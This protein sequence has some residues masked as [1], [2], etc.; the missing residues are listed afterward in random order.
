MPSSAR[1]G[2][3]PLM[4]PPRAGVDVR[5]A[6]QPDAERRQERRCLLLGERARGLPAGA[7]A[8]AGQPHEPRAL[9]RRRH[10]ARAR[11]VRWAFSVRP[12]CLDGVIEHRGCGH[13][14]AGTRTAEEQS[15]A[16]DAWSATP[17]SARRP[18]CTTDGCRRR[19]RVPAY[20]VTCASRH[21]ASDDR[22]DRAAEGGGVLKVRD[23]RRRGC[24]AARSATAPRCNRRSGAAARTASRRHRHH[25]GPCDG[26]GSA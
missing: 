9:R 24:R 12:D 14:R 4:V 11:Q 8:K 1:L 5:H 6:A 10:R 15:V 13:R 25:R 21:A 22:T 3:Q 19:M 26:S 2:Q 20:A 18:P 17:R 16:S 23:R 7:L